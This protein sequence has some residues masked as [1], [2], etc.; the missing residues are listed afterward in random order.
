MINAKF[1]L[2]L[3]AVVGALAC[4]SGSAQGGD[5]YAE[6]IRDMVRDEAQVELASWRQ[7]VPFVA[8][9]GIALEGL[10]TWGAAEL[11]QARMGTDHWHRYVVAARGGQ[12]WRLAGFSTH[13]ITGFYN[14][15]L[16][17]I[18]MPDNPEF[19]ARKLASLMD[20][21]GGE[22][23]FPADVSE[24]L[25]MI[26]QWR[27]VRPPSWPRDTTLRQAEDRIIARVT[28]LARNENSYSREWIP[29]MHSFLFDT[30]GRLLTALRREGAPFSATS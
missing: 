14:D 10:G 13:D 7:T 18:A 11:W 28:L 3:L 24:P 4:T 30:R 9:G 27:A 16:A 20:P 19:T 12:V 1:G 5:E 25:P 2:P 22:K 6:Q 8:R 17:E 29:V 21:Y 26:E 23:V 15:A